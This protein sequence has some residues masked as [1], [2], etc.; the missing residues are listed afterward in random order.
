MKGFSNLLRKQLLIILLL[1]AG[2]AFGQSKLDV[3]A[4]VKLLGT[5]NN[6]NED[7]I[8]PDITGVATSSQDYFIHNR[9]DVKYYPKPKWTFAVGMRNRLF[10]G[11][12]VHS[13]PGFA[14][15]L[16][17]DPGLV[18]LSFL[19]WQ[20][21][22]AL[23]H[24][25]FDRAFAQYENQKWN[26]RVGR[27]RINWGI[28]TVWNP[29]DVFNQYNYF[30]FDYEERPGTDAIRVQHFINYSSSIEIGYAPAEEAENSIAAALYKFNKWAYDFQLLAGYFQEDV[31]LGGGWAGNI[32]NAGFKGEFNQYIPTKRL[33]DENFI[34]SVA[35][36]YQFKIGLYM[37]VS[38]LYNQLGSNTANIS[39]FSAVNVQVQSAKN[40]FPFRHTAFI[41]LGF[42]M[43]PLMRFDW[44]TMASPKFDHF[45]AIPSLSY[46]LKDN[47][48]AL[49][50]A[51]LFVAK[52]P[53]NEDKIDWLS[54][55]VFARLKYSFGG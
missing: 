3:R 4:Y 33:G 18:D 17:T 47:L 20:S 54:A 32:K 1:V 29:N 31:T 24:T 35:V 43:T 15:A 36:D 9:F 5:F 14:R 41:Q 38:Y 7:F 45:I 50:T 30:D 40:I 25:T 12:N 13:N 21:D 34:A 39:D 37:Q 16:E 11:Y 27:Q 2:T 44:A 6:V 55:A 49:L 28:N 52:N 10:W 19:Y 42:N 46:S 51:Q 8:P 22:E 48:D 53:F 23:L 26:I